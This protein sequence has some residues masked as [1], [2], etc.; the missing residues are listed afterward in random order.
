M[1]KQLVIIAVVLLA[2]IASVSFYTVHIANA[3]N[4]M[5][6]SGGDKNMTTRSN[7][8]GAAR[9]TT[10]GSHGPSIHTTNPAG[11]KPFNKF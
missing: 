10:G 7:M 11:F 6:S 9:N 5:T 1:Q 2:G 4:N 3:Q 8:T